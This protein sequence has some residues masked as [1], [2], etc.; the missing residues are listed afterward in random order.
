M[1]KI[2]IIAVVLILAFI[3]WNYLSELRWHTY[4][5]ACDRIAHGHGIADTFGTSEEW[6]CQDSS[7]WE[8][9]IN[10]PGFETE[11]GLK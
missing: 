3:A 10:V 9:D 11:E 7:N 5:R 4:E 6:R 8:R 2:G 1:K